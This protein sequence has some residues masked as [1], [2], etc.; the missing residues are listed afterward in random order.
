MDDQGLSPI[1]DELPELSA[2]STQD[3]PTAVRESASAP[4]SPVR[5][6]KL[7]SKAA[8][9]PN[10]TQVLLILGLGLAALSLPL[11]LLRDRLMPQAAADRPAPSTSPLPSSASPTA[12]PA[13]MLGHSYYAEAPAAELVLLSSGDGILL[14]KAAAQKFEEMLEAAAAD[15]ISL[16]VISGFRSIADQNTLFFDVKAARGEDSAERAAVSAPPGYSEHHT[17]YA[18]DIGDSAAPSA[19]L[20]FSFE[21]TKAFKWLE[22]NAAY[23][24]FEMS[25]PK[26]N[27][28]GV[29]YEP[30][31]WRFVGDSQS[32]ETFYR[33]RSDSTLT[34]QNS[35]ADSDSGSASEN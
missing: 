29:S 7:N 14:R 22:R 9:Q 18:V 4:Y 13:E 10:L 12:S 25:F 5:S 11:W 24:S 31:H 21:Q 34:P 26:D 8:K 16:S 19:D 28:K 32:L 30:W 2:L 1:K 6:A 33:A 17:G 23:Y 35:P 3:I 27:L 20:Q 15:G